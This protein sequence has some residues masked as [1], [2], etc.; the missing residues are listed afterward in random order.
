MLRDGELAF[1]F[2]G[3]S[4]VVGAGCTVNIP[5]NA[6]HAFKNISDKTAHMLCLCSPAGQEEFFWALGIPL[7]SRTARPPHPTPEEMEAKGRLV[8]ALLP[9]Y[10]T[11]MVGVGAGAPP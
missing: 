2:R 7:E 4:Q 3:V 11:E 8:E 10:C 5:A 1:S 6:P 9:R